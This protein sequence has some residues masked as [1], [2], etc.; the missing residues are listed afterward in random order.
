MLVFIIP[1]IL[2][3]V[4]PILQWKFSLRRIKD[5]ISWPLSL[6][7]LLS[8]L[9]AAGL[10]ALAFIISL[11]GLP[12]DVKCATGCTVFISLGVVNV[13]F[14]VPLIG[15]IGSIRYYKAHQ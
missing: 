14:V 12:A 4:A 1:F 15:I 2:I 8:L 6:I 10:A 11:Y 5:Q 13:C 7:F 3:L 9:L